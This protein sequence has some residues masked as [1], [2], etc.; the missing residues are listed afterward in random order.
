MVGISRDVVIGEC[1]LINMGAMIDHRCV[2]GRC[3]HIPMN[4]V[5]RNEIAIPP[6]SEFKAGSVIE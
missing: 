5:V 2:I 6:M 4:A 1:C 3:T